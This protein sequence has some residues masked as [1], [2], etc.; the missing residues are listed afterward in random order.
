[1]ALFRDNLQ[2]LVGRVK[3]YKQNASSAQ[4][5]RWINDAIEDLARTRNWSDMIK[6]VVIS[7]PTPVSAGLVSLATG[8]TIVTGAGTSWPVAD[9]LDTTLPRQINSPGTTEFMIAEAQGRLVTEDS[10]LYVDGAGTP[11]AVPVLYKSGF[12]LTGSFQFSHPQGVSATQS[13]LAGLQLSLGSGSPVY[14]VLA[15]HSATELEIDAPWGGLPLTA[16]SYQILKMRTSVLPRCRHVLPGGVG[17]GQQIGIS[18]GISRRSLDVL[19]PSRGGGGSPLG[20]SEWGTGPNGNTLWEIWPASSSARQITVRAVQSWPELVSNNDRLP[21]FLDPA[22]VAKGAAAIALRTKINDDDKWYNPEL[23]RELKAEFE[24]DKLSAIN[25]DE[26]R[27]PLDYSND[28]DRVGAGLGPNT[29]WGM[30]HDL[31]AFTGNW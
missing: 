18:T 13:S 31:D 28:Y 3:D 17:A 9:V 8:S 12:N 24:R 29:A 21:A 20:L 14:T 5:Q 19:D 25:A 15:V 6:T 4:C 23:A 27:M 30:S 26:Y 22:I 7:I 1:M 16:V 10:I 11:E 2:T